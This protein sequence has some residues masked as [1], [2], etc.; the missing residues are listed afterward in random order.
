M[1]TIAEELAKRLGV[2]T[3]IYEERSR[4]DAKFGPQ[5]HPD[6]THASEYREYRRTAARQTCQ[7]AAAG[8]YL[9]WRHIL[10]E[11]VFEAF[12]EEDPAKLRTELVQCAAVCVAW[13]EALDRRNSQEAGA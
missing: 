2:Y 6:G 4:Q 5:N 1:P 9:T 8:G 10:A 11:E 12:A 3:E 13:I 7:D